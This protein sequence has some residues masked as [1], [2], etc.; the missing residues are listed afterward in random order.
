MPNASDVS[1]CASSG[2]MVPA[3]TPPSANWTNP[4]SDEVMP[5]I[6]GNRSS[7]SSVTLGMMRLE[8]NVNTKI[9]STFHATYGGSKALMSEFR[10]T[11][12]AATA[13]P[14]R[15]VSL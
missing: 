1:E 13:K 7:S 5:R 3:T 4:C 10:T 15:T 8:P 11:P 12:I 9:G 6:V 2:A 14:A